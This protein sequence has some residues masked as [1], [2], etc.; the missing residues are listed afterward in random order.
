MKKIL[1]CLIVLLATSA[2][3]QV[4]NP[5]IVLVVTAPSGACVAGLPNQQVLST[6]VLYTCQAGTWAAIGGGASSGVSSFATRTAAVVPVAGDYSSF[7]CLLTGCSIGGTA[8]NPVAITTT[9]ANAAIGVNSTYSTPGSIYLEA[10]C[11]GLNYECLIASNQFASNTP[12]FYFS[13]SVGGNGAGVIIGAQGFLG[14][15]NA[16]PPVIGGNTNVYLN[17]S[18]V[19]GQLQTS[20]NGGT[21][22]GNASGTSIL[23]A[24]M[25]LSAA[26][27]TVSCSTS[28]TAVFSQPEAGPSY[29]KIV[30]HEAACTGTA[31]YTYP[32]AFSFAPQV[33]SQSL[34]GTVTTI[35]TTA[36]TI[37]G[38]TSTGFLDLDG[39]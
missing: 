30:V 35:S 16:N 4:S 21:G 8:A 11:D 29:K 1:L 39:Y 19:G 36:V 2:F 24:Q 5:S 13:P 34:A 28:G 6:G 38:S 32:A 10:S 27:T 3:A 9:S 23:T 15:A 33:L 26:Q 7:Y 20:N 17:Y 18:G 12:L 31:S 37:T 14:F 25:D 22:A